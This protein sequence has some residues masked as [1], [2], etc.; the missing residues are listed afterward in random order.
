[1][2]VN[3]WVQDEGE[4]QR[5]AEAITELQRPASVPGIC[6]ALLA[7][8]YRGGQVSG[9]LDGSFRTSGYSTAETAPNQLSIFMRLNITV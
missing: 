5:S 1:M 2:G 6:A 4:V 7:C 8:R 9:H 3:D